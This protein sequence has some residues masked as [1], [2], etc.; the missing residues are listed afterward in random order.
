VNETK[1]IVKNSNYNILLIAIVSI[2]IALLLRFFYN[3]NFLNTDQFADLIEVKVKNQLDIVEDQAEWLEKNYKIQD[4]QFTTINAVANLPVF[5]FENERLIFWSS[6]HLVPAHKDLQ[7]SYKYHFISNAQGKFIVRKVSL[8]NAEAFI[9]LPVYY[10]YLI[11]NKYVEPGYNKEIINNSNVAIVPPEEEGAHKIEYQN[12]V[13]FGLKFQENYRTVLNPLSL[14]VSI[15]ILVSIILVL[16]LMYR[17]IKNLQKQGK[18]DYGL[19]VLIVTLLLFRFL[20]LVFNYP[21]GLI[22]FRLFNSI[23]YAS[24]IINPSLG[25]LLLNLLCVLFAAAY[26]YGHFHRFKSFHRLNAAS[27]QVKAIVA[28]ILITGNYLLLYLIYYIVRALNFH[29]QWSLDINSS[30]SFSYLKIV[31]LLII[32]LS[33]VFYLLISFVIYKTF[34]RLHRK[35]FFR[36]WFDLAVGIL[37]FVTIGLIFKFNFLLIAIVGTIYFVSLYFLNLPVYLNSIQYKT[38]LYLFATAVAFAFVG[39]YSIYTYDKEKEENRRERLAD[40]LLMDHDYHGEYLLFEA[41]EKIENDVLIKSRMLNPFF[42]STEVIKQKI[43]RVYLNNYFDKYEINIYLFG[44]NGEMLNQPVSE[45]NFYNFKEKYEAFA[46]DYDNIYFI[47]QRDV[48]IPKKYFAFVPIERF[49]Y[50]IGN[51]LIELNLKRLVPNSVYPELL[52]DQSYLQPYF[53]NNEFKDYSYA[54]FEEGQAIFSSGNFNYNNLN[55]SL[56][57]D[58]EFLEQGVVINDLLHYGKQSANRLIVVSS[59]PYP[60]FNYIS[61]FSFIFLLIIFCNFLLFGVYAIYFSFSEVNLNYAAKIQLYSNFAFFLPLLVVS[62]TTLSLLISSN[63]REVQNE[64]LTKA[65]NISYELVDPLYQYS[66]N[67]LAAGKEDLTSQL[68]Q[69]ARYSGVDI[70]L[71]NKK[72]RLIASSQPMIYENHLLSEYINPGAMAHIVEQQNNSVILDES[73]GELTY[74]STYVTVKYLTTGENIGILSIPF[75][76]SKLELD[77]QIIDI[78]TYIINIFTIIFIIFLIISY[79]A[80][81]WLTFPLRLITQKIRK[82][83]LAEVNEPLTWNSDD[84]IGLLIKEYNKMLENLEESKKALAR[85][86]KESAWREIARQVA[87]EIKNPL[88]PMKLTLQHLKRMMESDTTSK[89]NIATRPI[90]TLLHQINTLSDI[91]ESFSAF[92]K[93]PIPESE[94]FEISSILKKT[95]SLYQSREQ[96]HLETDIPQGI[97]YVIGDEQWMGRIFSNLIIN[98]FQ[99]VPEEREPVVKVI[100]QSTGSKLSI[101][102]RDNGTGIPEDIVDK[103]FI[104]N[105]STKSHGS[106]IGLAVA[107]RGVEHAGGKIWFETEEGKGTSFFIEL[108]LDKEVVK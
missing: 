6:Y 11:D 74:K 82:T 93:M 9:L 45:L 46:T 83:T 24:S 3:D 66:R 97:F 59:Q 21:G 75:F 99:S 68:I 95:I 15:L 100:M 60:F 20:M 10:N 58:E 29:S 64:Y 106:G 49:G 52:I 103:I 19:V 30:I 65:E 104:P 73:V 33:F 108:P 62:I 69:I 42:Q 77:N 88:T 56:F 47:N 23:Y 13:F 39:S 102:I 38:I 43:K 36:F 80:S 84:E 85:S 32:F 55:R 44:T 86:Q 63:H 72:G 40:Q 71:F 53:Y 28:T 87:H 5:I 50:N 54:V 1:F 18:Y 96:G 61:N 57:D 78:F 48:N 76:E 17:Y 94:R 2:A 7:G 41:L 26:L 27:E 98:G 31:S 92:A 101:E 22:A 89:D 90:N 51:I 14:L 35:A 107:K 79:F 105:F 81:K 34:V 67:R 12:H 8:E 16:I 37:I 70:N 91:A 4:R 25:D